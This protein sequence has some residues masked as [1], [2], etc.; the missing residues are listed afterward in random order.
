MVMKKNRRYHRIF[1]LTAQPLPPWLLRPFQP[2]CSAPST[3]T[4]PVFPWYFLVDCSDPSNF[5]HAHTRSV[6]NLMCSDFIEVIQMEFD[7]CIV[8]RWSNQW[9]NVLDG[10]DVQG[11][12]LSILRS[13]ITLR[14]FKNPWHSDDEAYRNFPWISAS[15]FRKFCNFW[16][17][18]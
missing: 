6:K 12:T 9:C 18:D 15:F 5:D 4:A 2:D 10:S 17:L 14:T 11:L 3:P 16:L 1:W 13:A 7:M 8:C